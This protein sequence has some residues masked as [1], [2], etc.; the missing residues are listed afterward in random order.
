MNVRR[1]AHTAM[2][3][4]LM[5]FLIGLLLPVRAASAGVDHARCDNGTSQAAAGGKEG[6]QTI[7]DKNHRVIGYLEVRGD[8]TFVR[9]PRYKLLGWA[10]RTGTYDAFGRKVLE[11]PVPSLLLEKPR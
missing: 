3:S 10:D 5:G 1:P 6:M 7:R 8:R 4:S 11:S 2:K 9:D